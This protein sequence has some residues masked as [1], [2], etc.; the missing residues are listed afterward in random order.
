MRRSTSA[1]VSGA[2]REHVGGLAL[3]QRGDVGRNE[4]ARR[5]RGVSS[6]S[7][8]A[9]ALASAAHAACARSPGTWRRPAPSSRS[10]E[11]RVGRARERRDEALVE[12]H[13]ARA[14]RAPRRGPAAGACAST[15]R[16]SRQPARRSER[17]SRSSGA[18]PQIRTPPLAGSAARRTTQP[19]G[20]GAELGRRG[21]R[22]ARSYHTPPRRVRLE[23][24]VGAAIATL[25]HI[26]DLHATRVPLLSLEAV[27]SKRALGWLSWHVRRRRRYRP[28]VLEALLADLARDRARPSRDHG[29]SHADRARAGVSR[30]GRLARAVRPARSRARDPR[31]PRCV[32]AGAAGKGMGALVRLSRERS[33]RG[34]DGYPER[35]RARRDRARGR[36]HGAADA[37]ARGDRPRRRGA[38]RAA[39]WRARAARRRRAVSRAADPSPA[40]ARAHVAPALAARRRP[41]SARCCARRGA[42]LV[43]HGHLHRTTLASLP[44][45]ERPIPVIGVPSASHAGPDPARCAAYHLYD[46]KRA[47]DGF[48]I[49]RRVRAWD[50]AI[51]RFAERG[52]QAGEMIAY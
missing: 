2:R 49:R 15:T 4:L 37:A 39:R 23:A 48:A 51:G 25:G 1:A 50:P 7:A 12:H 36:L 5:R 10:D 9:S 46:I 14:A 38:A 11:Q 32:R 18:R 6:G 27:R 24:A 44:G 29:R 40:R 41:R 34:I 8:S 22:A 16:R 13:V 47:I 17:S 21:H 45:P 35:A 19:A 20:A 52:S 30:G 31:Q 3:A 33:R 43:L 26:S 42:E 28:A